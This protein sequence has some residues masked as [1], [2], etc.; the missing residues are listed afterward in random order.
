MNSL[1][2]NRAVCFIALLATLVFSFYSSGSLLAADEPETEIKEEAPQAEMVVAPAEEGEKTFWQTPWP[3]I[4]GGA[5]VVGG[6]V[7]LALALSGGGGGGDDDNYDLTGHW[8]M[9]VKWAT[10]SYTVRTYW[11]FSSDK[12]F[13][14]GD[15]YTGTWSVSGSSVSIRYSLGTLYTGTLD[16]NTH[17]SGTV[18]SYAGV[19]GTWYADRSAGGAVS[20]PGATM[21]VGDSDTAGTAQ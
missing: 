12:T 11:D 18:V 8:S 15:G 5:V 19:H 17:M 14:S 21:G 10:S 13:R 20:D 3:W 9:G 1:A 6:G 7:A 16:S 4:I 2:H